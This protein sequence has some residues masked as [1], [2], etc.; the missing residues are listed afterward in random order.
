MGPG[1][2]GDIPSGRQ[3]GTNAGMS[4]GMPFDMAGTTGAG[5]AGGA[6]AG[7]RGGPH[8]SFANREYSR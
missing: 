6:M 5:V 1:T 4:K 8:P 7:G 3:D 2:G